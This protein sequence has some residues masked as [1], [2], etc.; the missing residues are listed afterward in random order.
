MKT[1]KNS[2]KYSGNRYKEPVEDDM[3][4]LVGNIKELH[5]EID[6]MLDEKLKVIDR[7]MEKNKECPCGEESCEISPVKFEE[8]DSLYGELLK[9]EELEKKFELFMGNLREE[10]NI[11]SIQREEE[12]SVILERVKKIQDL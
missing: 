12:D 1:Q 4:E 8:I 2:E 10:K 7:C 9:D 11:S 5:R 3:E 6:E